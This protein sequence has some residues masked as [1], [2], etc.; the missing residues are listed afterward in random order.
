[1]PRP[2]PIPAPRDLRLLARTAVEG[3]VSG[4]HASPHKGGGADFRQHRPYVPG[5]DLRAL[6]WK[7]YGKSDRFYV[8]EFDADTNLRATLLVDA[9]ASMNYDGGGEANR[10]DYACALAASLAYL[11]LRQGDAV[12]LATFDKGLRDYAPPA[13]TPGHLTRLLD[14][15]AAARPAPGPERATDFAAVFRDVAPKLDRHARR[16]MTLLVSDC[17]GNANALANGL[18]QAR[19]S[20]QDVIV[21]EVLHP[22]ESDFDFR[23]NV[24]FDGLEGDGRRSL[25]ARLLRGRYLEKL[26]AHRASVALGCARAKAQLVRVRSDEPLADVLLRF[27]ALRARRATAGVA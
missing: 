12:A 21:F 6:D 7:V 24:Q 11:L 27:L 9:S 20:R 25:D 8:R 5:D 15:L 4:I 14:L 26:A 13:S 1:M 16:G 3:V 22:D 23:G 10:F 18:L 19:R 2:E 17:F